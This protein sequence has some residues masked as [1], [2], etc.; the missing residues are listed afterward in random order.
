MEVN[1]EILRKIAHLARLK[2][3]DEEEE[4]MAES[5]SEILTWVEKLNELDTQGVAPLTNMTDETNS[6]R[7]DS[8]KK[9]ISRTQA[10]NNAPD[11]DDQFFKVP[12][13]IE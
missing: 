12:K 4:S 5:L 13:V 7:E 3:S 11:K 6:W 10:L 2:F 1:K 8:V 9:D